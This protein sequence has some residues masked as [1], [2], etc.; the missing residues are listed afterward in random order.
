MGVE[1]GCVVPAT[2]RARGDGLQLECGMDRKTEIA[3]WNRALRHSMRL[4]EDFEVLGED[5]YL[6]V[7]LRHRITWRL[8]EL[9]AFLD[10]DEQQRLDEAA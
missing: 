1:V 6:L 9:G 5:L 4:T 8:V 3:W 7:V 2:D 10:Y